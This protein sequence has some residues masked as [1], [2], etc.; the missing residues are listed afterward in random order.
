MV[1]NRLQVAMNG[2][3]IGELTRH[4]N[5]GLSFRYHTS[6]LNSSVGRALS[7]SLPLQVKAWEGDIVYNFFDNLLP[8]NE[9]IRQRIQT[10]FGVKTNTPFDLLASIGMD[11]VGAIQLYSEDNIPPTTAVEAEPL[12]DTQLEHLVLNYRT[13]P[14][15]M[16]FDNDAFRI[17]LAGAQEKTALFWNG[18]QWCKPKGS[19]ATTHIIKLPIGLLEGQG[20]NLEESC[21]NEWL[22][23][24][25]LGAY[26]L[27]VPEA[28][29]SRFGEQQVLA[30]KRFDRR[31]SANGTR[32]LRLPQEDFCQAMG[33]APSFKYEQDGGPGIKECMSLL[34][35]SRLSL[36]DRGLF[37]KSQI[38]FW[39]LA[40]IDGHAK[41]FSLFIEPGTHFV[42]TPFY[43]VISARPFENS[44]QFH[45]RKVAMAMS[46][47]GTTSRHKKVFSIQPRHFIST[48]KKV[49]FSETQVHSMMMDIVKMTPTVVSDITNNLPDNFPEHISQPIVRGVEHTS[50][51]IEEYLNRI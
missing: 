26:G 3:P 27:P 35:G 2:S 42:M 23:L 21:E 17:S 51:L 44:A 34:N 11:C 8:D 14:L 1:T 15:G 24:K 32:L 33:Y 7:L 20:I 10:R 40:A 18:K 28:T 12:D 9:K 46:L 50:N 48:A 36:Q 30:V 29:L 5:G 22:C 49:G 38:L 37:F 31:W 47:Y 13:S 6:W 43:D 25:I 19:T 41:N 39:M 4:R 16:S 45:E